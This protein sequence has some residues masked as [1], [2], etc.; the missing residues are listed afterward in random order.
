M[1]EFLKN[2]LKNEFFLA[3]YGLYQFKVKNNCERGVEYYSKAMRR[4]KNELIFTE[5]KIKCRTELAKYY[6]RN[7]EKKKA[8]LEAHGIIKKCPPQL[9]WYANEAQKILKEKF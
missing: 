2:I 4:T 6:L 7:G 9:F 5:L 3:T 1:G 8:Q